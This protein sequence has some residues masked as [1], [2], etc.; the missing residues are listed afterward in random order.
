MFS[1]LPAQSGFNGPSLISSELIR[2]AKVTRSAH[3]IQ[4]GR[5]SAGT[6][7]LGKDVSDVVEE[8][9]ANCWASSAPG[10]PDTRRSV[11]LARALLR[12]KLFLQFARLRIVAWSQRFVNSPNCVGLVLEGLAFLRRGSLSVV[13]FETVS[14]GYGIAAGARPLFE[15]APALKHLTQC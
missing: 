1:R 8:E 5:E 3:L 15:S 2:P 12:T 6:G 7:R 9:I 14:N 13:K 4:L 11:G 10:T